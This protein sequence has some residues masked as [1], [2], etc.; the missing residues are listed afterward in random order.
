MQGDL[1]GDSLEQLCG[2]APKGATLV[3]FH[4]AVL[5]YVADLSD[6]RT[7]ADRRDAARH[8]DRQRKARRFPRYRTAHR[9]ARRTRP[10]SAVGNGAPVAWTD[11]HGASLDWIAA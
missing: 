7:F 5:A 10:L 2:E 6:R 9:G 8:L 11:P 1:L 4:T 3:I